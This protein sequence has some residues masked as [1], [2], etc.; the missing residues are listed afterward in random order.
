MKRRWKQFLAGIMTAVMLFG[1]L[2]T[3]A[4]AAL[5]DN[6]PA[7]NQ[8]ILAHLKQLCGSED[9]AEAYDPV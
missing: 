7:Y 5:I 4:F 2:P 1:L 9:E 3:A 8:E 6:D